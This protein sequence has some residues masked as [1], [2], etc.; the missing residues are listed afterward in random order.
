MKRSGAPGRCAQ[1]FKPCRGVSKRPSCALTG[2]EPK[3]YAPRGFTPGCYLAP[4]WGSDLNQ[5]SFKTRSYISP[6]PEAMK[7]ASSHRTPQASPLPIVL[8]D[9]SLICILCNQMKCGSNQCGKLP[10]IDPHSSASLVRSVF[11]SNSAWLGSLSTH[12]SP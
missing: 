10:L 3:P 8:V 2:L 1:S 7:A 11:N 4:R 9:P 5:A 12:S 6:E